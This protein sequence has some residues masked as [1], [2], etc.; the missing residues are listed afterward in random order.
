MRC[1]PSVGKEPVHL[2]GGHGRYVHKAIPNRCHHWRIL[3][4]LNRLQFENNDNNLVFPFLILCRRNNDGVR[5]G[6]FRRIHSLLRYKYVIFSPPSPP[7]PNNQHHAIGFDIKVVS[8]ANYSNN[9]RFGSNQKSASASSASY[10]A[11]VL[12]SS[13]SSASPSFLRGRIF[14]PSPQSPSVSGL[15]VRRRNLGATSPAASG[16]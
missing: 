3:L 10:S 14:L 11:S 4:L 8:C 1:P 5:Q 9:R 7:D 6:K 13:A 12:A 2:V 15:H 16:S